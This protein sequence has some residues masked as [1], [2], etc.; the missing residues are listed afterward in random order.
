MTA[1]IPDRLEYQ[2]QKLSLFTNPLDALP[3]DRKP[4]FVSESTLN[5]RG[6]VALWEV[7]DGRLYLKDLRGRICAKPPESDAPPAKCG[8]HHRGPCTIESVDLQGA[9]PGRG[10]PIFAD[11][12]TGELKV[13]QGRLLEYVHM[14]YASR[15][16]RYL[17]IDVA[18]GAIV[19]AREI[20]SDPPSR[21]P[22][23]SIA[24]WVKSY[25]RRMGSR[26]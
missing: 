1:Q 24:R 2:G 19:Q 18:A 7:R 9:F 12:Y 26:G 3:A 14:G 20:K 22:L 6:Y 16:E 17:M 10:A 11:W 23:R 15:Y 13:P 8:R 25:A 21:T 5:W 4:A